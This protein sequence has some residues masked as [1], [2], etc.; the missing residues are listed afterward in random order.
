LKQKTNAKRVLHYERSHVLN[1]RSKPVNANQCPV[2]DQQTGEVQHRIPVFVVAV[3]T[4][5]FQT[6][7]RN[8]NARDPQKPS[9]S[10]K[11]FLQIV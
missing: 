4:K 7:R 8:G 6:T 5:D 9:V 10:S 2:Y 11:W 1:E 3:S